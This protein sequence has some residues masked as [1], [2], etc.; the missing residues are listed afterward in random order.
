V[1]G[2][3]SELREYVPQDADAMRE[4]VMVVLNDIV[5]LTDESGGFFVGKVKVH[6]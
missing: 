1:D 5:Q 3:G 6:P 4:R 2:L